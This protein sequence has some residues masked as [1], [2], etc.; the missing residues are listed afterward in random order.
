VTCFVYEVYEID[1]KFFLANIL[2]L[3][4]CLRLELSCIWVN[5]V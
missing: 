5:R 2:F 1:S 4:G 3:R